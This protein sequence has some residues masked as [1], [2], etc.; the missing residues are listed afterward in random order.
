MFH[1]DDYAIVDCFYIVHAVL[2]NPCEERDHSASSSM[3]AS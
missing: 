1:C 3:A 2:V